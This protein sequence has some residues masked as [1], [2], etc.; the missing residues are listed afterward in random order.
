M[1]DIM[2][3]NCD[4]RA[5]QYLLNSCERN[6]IVDLNQS[7][8]THQYEHLLRRSHETDL[9]SISGIGFLYKC[10]HDIFGRPVVCVIGKW[11]KFTEIDKE[12][13]LLYLI[14]LLD[15]VASTGY[16]VIY[17]HT[18]TLSENH[19]TLSWIRQVYNVLEYRLKK[20]LKA[21]Y[22]VHPTWWSRMVIWWFTTFR[23]SSI[24][25]KIHNVSGVEYLYSVIKED[26]LEV[27]AF[28]TEYDMS[29]NGFRYYRPTVD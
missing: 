11:F 24:K 25:K 9:S 29:T 17:F 12:L 13:A 18:S 10:G 4:D 19:P 20:N 5:K 1:A 8:S 14:R 6:T 23:A 7:T 21:F 3:Q 15:S 2:E 16:T 27:P 28:I 26:Q 22:I